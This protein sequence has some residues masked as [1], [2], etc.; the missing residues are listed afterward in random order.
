MR[1]LTQVWVFFL[2]LTF[3][4]LLL[5]FQLAGRAGLLIAF[6]ISLYIVYATLHRGL[7]LFKKKLNAKEFNGHDPSGFLTEIQNHK[8]KFGFK[9]IN[10]YRTDQNSPPLIWKSKTGEGHFVL[11]QSLLNNLN[12]EEIRFLALLFLSHLECR[13][14]LVTPILS[15]INQSFYNFNIFS[16]L[17]SAGVTFILDTKSDILKA[18]I[19][20]R[21]ISNASKYELGFFIN[22]LHRF[23][24][25]Q[26]KKQIGTEYFSI[27]SLRKNNLLNQYGIP[28][29]QVRLKNLMG[30][31]I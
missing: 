5:G 9:K 12:R 1:T 24:F 18:D 13:S 29:L 22:K 30:F 7:K 23:G 31:A 28:D 14:F 25:N 26:N 19:K 2:T 8:M 20:F 27:L 11:N 17:L 10:V 4:F 16:V 21:N 3:L 6:L 15:V